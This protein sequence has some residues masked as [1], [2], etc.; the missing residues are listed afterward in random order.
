MALEEVGAQ[1]A[2][3]AL[4]KRRLFLKRDLPFMRVVFIESKLTLPSTYSLVG[5]N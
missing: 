1:E 3:A 2:G 4:R 5:K